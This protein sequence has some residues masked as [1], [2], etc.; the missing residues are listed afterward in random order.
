METSGSQQNIV[1][2]AGNLPAHSVAS[3]R[4]GQCLVMWEI[5]GDPGKYCHCT[6]LL[7]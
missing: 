4:T 1:L 2:F 6:L 7:D 5:G 3:A